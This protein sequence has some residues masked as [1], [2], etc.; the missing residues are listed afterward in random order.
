MHVLLMPGIFLALITVHLMLV[1]YQKHTQYP[2]PGRTEKNAVGYPFFPVYTAKAGGFFFITFGVTTLLSAFATI[3]PIWLFGPYNPTQVSAGSQPDWYMGFLEGILRMFPNWEIHL[4]GLHVSLN[5]LGADPDHPR[6]AVHRRWPSTRSRTL[7]HRRQ[8]GAPCPGP[9]AQRADPHR[10]RR[11]GLVTWLILLAG[12]ANDILAMTFHL[13]IN[14]IT[15]SFR[16]LIFVLPPMAYV[17]TKRICLGLQRRDRELVLHGRETGR[18]VRLPH[19]EM[20]EVHEPISEAASGSSP[21]TWSA[22]PYQVGPV[23]DANG[24]PRRSSCS[25]RPGPG[26]P[27]STSRTGSMP[28]TPAE[29]RELEASPLDG[30][31]IDG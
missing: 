13:S 17:V 15:N 1:W 10:A 30:G 3:N 4:L 6:P 26:C 9:A 31:R 23:T 7:G 2:R 24:V 16:V 20:I 25:P 22:T 11:A 28:P 29:V 19:G 21:S 14:T 8:R 12:G 27:G 18:I 5:V